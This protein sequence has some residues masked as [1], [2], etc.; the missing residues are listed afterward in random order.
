MDIGCSH[1]IYGMIQDQHR[2]QLI[3]VKFKKIEQ[4][5]VPSLGGDLIAV[6]LKNKPD[7]VPIDGDII[8]VLAEFQKH[9][10]TITNN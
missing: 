4:I 6:H 8:E 3:Y 9:L 2:L 1:P 10:I 7:P 5:N